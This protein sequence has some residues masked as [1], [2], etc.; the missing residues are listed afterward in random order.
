MYINKVKF[1]LEVV[2]IVMLLFVFSII[3]FKFKNGELGLVS[4]GV[5]LS[6]IGIVITGVMF[7]LATKRDSS[8]I[9]MTL[10]LVFAV[11]GVA[12]FVYGCFLV[13]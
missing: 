13:Y 1:G 7:V 4:F 12:L 9:E 11:L 6:V 8:W 5:T 3:G 2:P 10:K